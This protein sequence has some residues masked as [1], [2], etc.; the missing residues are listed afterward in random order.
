MTELETQ[1]A[2]LERLESAYDDMLLGNR[3]NKG[4]VEGLGNAEFQSVSATTLQTEII[5]TKRKIARLQGK[6]SRMIGT[7]NVRGGR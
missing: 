1:K 3:L 5:K 2:R 4:D 6:S 7:P